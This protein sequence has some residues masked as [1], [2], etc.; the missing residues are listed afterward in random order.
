MTNTEIIAAHYA[1][2][3]TGDLPGM[4]A[5]F[6]P[7]VVWT[8]AAGFPLAGTYVGPEAVTH[9]VFVKLQEDWE[10][11]TVVVDELLDAGPTVVGIGT[12]S[13]TNRRTGK[14]FSARFVHVWRLEHE[15][16]VRFEQIVDSSLVVDA[17]P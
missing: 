5:S 2:S 10:G 6:S 17:M 3:E 16:V 12:Y 1:A 14:S 7:E 13:G 9:G 8:E 11:F 4:L 15:K